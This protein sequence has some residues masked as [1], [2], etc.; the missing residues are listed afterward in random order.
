MYFEHS[1]VTSQS[2][3][4]PQPMTED[5]EVTLPRSIMDLDPPLLQIIDEDSLDVVLNPLSNEATM[6]GISRR[7]AHKRFQVLGQDL[8]KFAA[9]R[10]LWD[11]YP[12]DTAIAVQK[13]RDMFCTNHQLAI[14]AKLYRLTTSLQSTGANITDVEKTYAGIFEAYVGAAI[15]EMSIDRVYD[16]VHRICKSYGQETEPSEQ[17]RDNQPVMSPPPLPVPPSGHLPNISPRY[18]PGAMGTTGFNYNYPPPNAY[19]SPQ[20]SRDPRIKQDPDEYH[21][22]M[23][24]ISSRPAYP[25]QPQPAPYFQQ[26]AYRQTPVFPATA[27]KV[28]GSL[29]ALRQKATQLK[30]EVSFTDASTGP[31]HQKTWTCSLLVDHIEVGVGT[32]SSKQVAKDI[33]AQQGLIYLG[34]I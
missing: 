6:S 11:K 3:D 13:K 27:S 16:W 22:S 29:A 26:P 20:P 34:W 2:E 1:A 9:L 31:D 10:F 30:R 21:P 28:S 32:A 8:I 25:S 24:L 5:G 7:A 18:P 4:V 23:P 33:A 19:G 15:V 14:F 17:L 12:M